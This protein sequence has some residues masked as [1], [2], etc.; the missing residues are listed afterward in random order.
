MTYVD[1]GGVSANVQ[2]RPP[3]A[4]SST[5]VLAELLSTVHVVGGADD[6]A[7]DRLEVGLV[8]V[9]PRHPGEVALEA[10]PDVDELVAGVDGPLDPV[11]AGGVGLRRRDHEDVLGA[12]VGQRQPAPLAVDGSSATPLSVAERTSATQST[13]VDAPGSRQVKV[14]VEVA[15]STSPSSRPRRSTAMS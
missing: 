4:R 9:R 3:S 1:S 5:E 15:S 13:N 10:G 2:R 14:M 6:E 11:G 7:V 12:E 8:E